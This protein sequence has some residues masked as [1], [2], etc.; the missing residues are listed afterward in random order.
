MQPE[1][2][3]VK[4]Y[5]RLQSFPR[6]TIRDRVARGNFRTLQLHATNADDPTSRYERLAAHFNSFHLI[7]EEG[8]EELTLR[9]MD[10]NRCD[11]YSGL[12][13]REERESQ[14]FRPIWN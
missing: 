11:I 1:R 5:F 6:I 13:G 2:A 7:R 9:Q 8:T 14:R 4:L 12:G 10:H 3:D